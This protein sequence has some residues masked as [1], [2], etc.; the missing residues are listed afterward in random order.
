M[1]SKHYFPEHNIP[2]SYHYTNNAAYKFTLIIIDLFS[3]N[4]FVISYC[5][6]H[7]RQFP[8]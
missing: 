1:L 5:F 7:L 3:F 6:R 4:I 8:L 2:N